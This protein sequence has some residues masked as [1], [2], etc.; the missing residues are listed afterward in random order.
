MARVFIDRNL[1][2]GCGLCVA[3]CDEVFRSDFDGKAE[4]LMDSNP[5]LPCVQEAIDGCPAEAI[6][7][8]EF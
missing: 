5:D 2:V 6:T 7:V 8:E 4:V 3:I 1:C